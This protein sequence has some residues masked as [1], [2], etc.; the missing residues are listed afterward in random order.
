[1]AQLNTLKG[2]LCSA[3]VLQPPDL[4][5]PLYVHTDAS[6]RALGAV[7]THKR[8]SGAQEFEKTL[9][10]WMAEFHTYW[11]SPI[12]LPETDPEKETAVDAVKAAVCANINLFMEVPYRLSGME[13]CGC[14]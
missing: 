9:D 14:S 8:M 5:Q 6:K 4:A 10:A 13:G 3:R 2:K 7:L 12:A 11:R 1:M